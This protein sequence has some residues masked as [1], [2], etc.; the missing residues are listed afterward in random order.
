MV[1]SVFL[2]VSIV[3]ACFTASALMRGRRLHVFVI[4]YFFGAWLTGELALHHLAWQ[5]L[6]TVVFVALGALEAWPGLVG[7][8]VTGLSWVGLLVLQRRAGK[9]R[10]TFEQ[11]LRDGMGNG[12]G[13]RS[14]VSAPGP[15]LERNIPVRRLARPFKM[16]DPAVECV[17]NIPYGSAGKRNLLDVYRARS[18]PQGCPTLLQIHGGGWV[19]GEKEQQGLPL[20]NRLAA[21]G[22]VCVAPNYRLSPK[23]TF[24]DHLIDVKR[25]LA[26]VRDHGPSFGADPDFIAVTGGSAGGHLAALVALTP[27][28][29]ELQPGFEDVDTSVAACVPFYGIYDF[30]DRHGTRGWQAMTPFLARVVMKCR[31]DAALERWQQAS[32]IALVRPDAPPFFVIHGTHDSLAFVEDARHFVRSLRSVSRNPVVFAEIPGAQ[33]AFDV[34]HSVRSRHAV[35]AVHSFLA[36]THARYRCEKDSTLTAAAHPTL[37]GG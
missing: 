33:H 4:P 25:A 24:P 19:I 36:H 13:E 17:R 35:N 12:D 21:E 20:M 15:T 8:A 9:A 7:L 1:P 18:R 2:A 37:V 34:F 3:G 23:A 30:L 6:A 16:R 11:A 14:R 29:P 32:P 27:N 28:V 10:E 31:P 5:A 26:W 22:W